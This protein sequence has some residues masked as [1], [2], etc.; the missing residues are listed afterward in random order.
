MSAVRVRLPPPAGLRVKPAG[1]RVKLKKIKER[2]Q[3]EMKVELLD[4]NPVRTLK[5]A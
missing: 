3:Q 2:I 4:V 1:L 5:T